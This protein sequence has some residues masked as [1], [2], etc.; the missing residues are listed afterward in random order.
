MEPDANNELSTQLYA[1]K[2]GV[3]ESVG[4]KDRMYSRAKVPASTKALAW[5]AKSLRSHRRKQPILRKPSVV[6]VPSDHTTY[7]RRKSFA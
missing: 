4:S 6:G 5:R 3:F 2:N 7:D 1:L